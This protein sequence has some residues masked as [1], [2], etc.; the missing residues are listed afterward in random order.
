[1]LLFVSETSVLCG[2]TSAYLVRDDSLPVQVSQNELRSFSSKSGDQT[3]D[4]QSSTVS[5]PLTTATSSPS[6]TSSS[7]SSEVEQAENRNPKRKLK[8]K[9]KDFL[10]RLK[11]VRSEAQ[12]TPTVP[13]DSTS[14]RS[15]LET[16]PSGGSI[17]TDTV[18][19]GVCMFPALPQSENKKSSACVEANKKQ[20]NNSDVSMFS[21]PPTLKYKQ[22]LSRIKQ[23]EK[24]KYWLRKFSSSSSISSSDSD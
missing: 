10:Q 4:L 8:W 16:S 3:D 9:V 5:F 17:S 22:I 2:S 19:S 13:A 11:R 6:S 24:R 18:D 14:D 12:S 15:S 1:M 20:K 23:N 21:S 7:S